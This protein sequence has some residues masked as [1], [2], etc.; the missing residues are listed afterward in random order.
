MLQL[1]NIY[2][3]QGKVI[4]PELQKTSLEVNKGALIE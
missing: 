3:G 1:K 4:K 2:Q